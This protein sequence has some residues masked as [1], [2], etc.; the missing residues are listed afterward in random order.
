MACARASSHGG[1]RRRAGGQTDAPFSA[2]SWSSTW[3]W[4]TCSYTLTRSCTTHRFAPARGAQSQGSSDASITCHRAPRHAAQHDW[5]SGAGKPETCTNATNGRG[6]GSG[7]G[8]KRARACRGRGGA[9]RGAPCPPP[10]HRVF[11]CCARDAERERVVL[12]RFFAAT[13][14]R[15]RATVSG[16]DLGGIP[17]LQVLQNKNNEPTH[18]LYAA[19]RGQ[20]CKFPVKFLV[21]DSGGLATRRRPTG[22]QAGPPVCARRAT[23]AQ[24]AFSTLMNLT[25]FVTIRRKCPAN[26]SFDRKV[27]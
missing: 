24:T 4:V 1:R 2:A 17:P 21:V 27:L 8:A 10:A 5:A 19:D 9:R 23:R 26:L 11:G 12:R 16:L 20:H 15:S 3:F 25:F 14:V 13:Q 7:V 6:G 18:T 22:G